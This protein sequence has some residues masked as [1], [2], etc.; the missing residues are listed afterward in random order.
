MISFSTIGINIQCL[1]LGSKLDHIF[2][3][4]GIFRNQNQKYRDMKR[5]KEIKTYFDLNLG[6]F[7]FGTK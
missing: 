3:I 5:K 7:L 6:L 1:T 2:K 4:V